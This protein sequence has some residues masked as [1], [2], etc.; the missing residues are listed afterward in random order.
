MTRLHIGVARLAGGVVALG[1]LSACSGYT[2]IAHAQTAG[3]QAVSA[4]PSSQTVLSMS[5]IIARARSLGFSDLSEIELEEG[6]Y[7]VEALDQDG[8]RVEVFFDAT[9]GDVI[10]DAEVHGDPMSERMTIQQILTKAQD[11]GFTNISE[12]ERE[13]DQFCVK[14]RNLDGEEVE[15]FLDAKTGELVEGDSAS[16][17]DPAELSEDA[18]RAKLES[19]GF[20]NIRKIEREKESGKYW[21]LASD[22]NGEDVELHIDRITGEI[23]RREQRSN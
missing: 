20:S 22:E 7:C 6:R 4:T 12:I 10:P 19:E 8:K 16:S 11:L 14:A 9:T 23:T 1:V 13:G 5:E 17:D 21:V 18:V 3:E 2:S 15:I